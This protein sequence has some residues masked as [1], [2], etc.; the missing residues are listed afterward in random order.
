[1]EHRVDLLFRRNETV[2]PYLSLILLPKEIWK[3]FIRFQVFF[4]VKE[5]YWE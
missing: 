2:D 5:I 1:M 4:V 3:R